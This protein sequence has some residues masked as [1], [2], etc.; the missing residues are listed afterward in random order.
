MGR[1]PGKPRTS[2]QG[3]IQAGLNSEASKPT[4]PTKDALGTFL[5]WAL[6]N[7]KMFHGYRVLAAGGTYV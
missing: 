1:V 4:Q 6:Q 3:K 2:L 5:S 7:G